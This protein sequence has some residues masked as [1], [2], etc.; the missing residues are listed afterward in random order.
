MKQETKDA[1][2]KELSIAGK[3]VGKK[4]LN[5][6]SEG[7]TDVALHATNKAVNKSKQRIDKK[8]TT[9]KGGSLTKIQLYQLAKR[10]NIY[11]RSTMNKAEL[12]RALNI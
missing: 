12:I 3:T 11:K 1:I 8:Y 5:I 9:Q 10:K 7:I 6:F 2:K 4:I